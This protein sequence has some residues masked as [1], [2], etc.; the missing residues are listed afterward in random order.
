MGAGV[1]AQAGLGGEGAADEVLDWLPEQALVP[2]QG[3]PGPADLDLAR[4]LI[5]VA[6]TAADSGL[7]ILGPA[8]VV[9]A[10]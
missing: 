4:A 1:R 2:A 8:V 10:G 5:G 3:Q 7:S 6:W 9:H